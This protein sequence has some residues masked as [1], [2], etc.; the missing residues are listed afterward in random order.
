VLVCIAVFAASL[1]RKAGWREYKRGVEIKSKKC[2][3]KV[4]QRW[5]EP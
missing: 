1:L 3:L 4:L 5:S 2:K